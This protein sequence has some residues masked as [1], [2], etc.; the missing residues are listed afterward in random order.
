MIFYWY[1]YSTIQYQ[2]NGQYNIIIIIKYNDINIII[3]VI[4]CTILMANVY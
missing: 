4:Q 3:N 1:Y 2:Y